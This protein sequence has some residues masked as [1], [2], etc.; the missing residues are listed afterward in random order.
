M[1]DRIIHFS[2]YHKLIVGICIVGLVTWGIYSLA[3]LPIDAV[4]DI[5]DNQVQVITRSPDLSAQEVERFITYP[6]ELE[7][8]NIPNVQQIRSISRFGLSVITVVFQEHVDI[9]WARQQISQNIQRAGS[10]IPE[11]LGRPEMGPISTGLGEVYQYV[12]YAQEGYQDQF[13]DTDLRS[14]QDWIIRR[15]LIGIPGVVEVNSSGGHLKQYEVAIDHS[16]LESFHLTMQDVLRAVEQNNEN[17]GGSYIEKQDYRYFIRGEGLLTDMDDIGN[18]VVVSRP[19]GYVLL[20]DVAEITIGHAPRFG[21][22]TLDG[23]GEVVAGQ[24]MMLKGANSMEVTRRVKEKMEVIK[25]GLPEGIV[26][27]PYLDRSKLVNSTTHTVAKNLIEGALIVI[28]ILVLLLGNLRAGLIVA[29]V[30]PL[31]MLFA[32][33]MMRLFGVSAN[34]MSLGAI[35]FG[36]I[37]DGAVIIVESILHHLGL[38]NRK[39]NATP[40]EQEAAVYTAASKIRRSA[41]FGEIIIL[42]V[43]LPILFLQGVEGKM[44]QPMAQT[45]SFAILGA[46]LLSLTYVP[47][48]SALFLKNSVENEQSL[49]QRI[50][51]RIYRIY[52]PMLDWALRHAAWILVPTI[53]LFIFSMYTLTRMGG[54]FIPTLEEGDFALHQILPSGSSLQKGVEV[55]AHLQEILTSKFPE[56]EKVVT[57]IG[58]AEIPTDIMPI[59]AGDIFVILKPK[60]EWVT[61]RSR[62][63]MFMAME[64]ELERFPGVIYE[65]TQPI[66]MRFNELMTGIRQDIAIKIYGED[67][68]VLVHLAHQAEGLLQAL[69]GIGDIQVEPT[70]GLQQMVIKYDRQKIAAYGVS[71]QALSDLIKTAF[72]GKKAGVLYEGDRK[73]DII[74]RLNKD[75]RQ[76][77]DNI[78]ELRVVLPSGGYAPLSEMATVSFEE[79]P[80]QISRDDTK[81][82]ITI[83]VNARN[84]DVATLIENIQTSFEQEL[85]LPPGYYVAYGGN[86]ENLERARARLGVVVPLA[87]GLIFILLYLTFHSVRHALL[88]FTAIPLSAIGGIWALYWRAMPFSISAGV[89]FIALFGVAV[90]NGI[91]L[92][93]YF[94]QLKEEGMT[95]LREIITEGTRIRLRPVL[96]TA[97][98]ASMGFLPM[99]LSAS[100]GAEVQRPLATVVIGGLITATFLTLF[101]IP[102]LYDIMERRLHRRTGQIAAVTSVL[103]VAGAWSTWAQPVPVLTLQE[104]IDLAID[105]NPQMKS[106]DTRSMAWQELAKT[107]V[108][109]LPL[110]LQVTGEEFDGNNQGIHSLG[111]FKS[112]RI[113]DLKGAYRNFYHGQSA[114]ERNR[115]QIQM[116]QLARQVG[117]D[118]L[119]LAAAR[120]QAEIYREKTES[121]QALY[122][123]N[124]RRLELGESGRLPMQQAEIKRQESQ[125]QLDQLE[126]EIQARADALEQWYPGAIFEVQPLEEIDTPEDTLISEHPW[127]TSF[128]LQQQSFA[129]QAAIT[130]QNNRPALNGGLRLQSVVGEFPFFGYQIGLSIPMAGSYVRQQRDAAKI[131]QDALAQER[132]FAQTQLDRNQVLL[133]SEMLQAQASAADLRD[134]LLPRAA[135]LVADY[136]VGFKAGEADYLEVVLASDAYFDLRE[137]LVGQMKK[138]LSRKLFLQYLIAE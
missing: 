43:Y 4:P 67:L 88:I 74:V 130:S 1:I 18:I 113:G 48:M 54:E 57:K 46:L 92:V 138:Y 59:E 104:A 70:A 124:K 127:L 76:G 135:Q 85:D 75:D 80:S 79:G 136:Q 36:L 73:Y 105:Q 109:D 69:P 131:R 47:M 40:A 99:A 72:A 39:A 44:F 13:D 133:Q 95:D 106:F 112:F 24:V 87:L 111:A 21:A 94:N 93:G 3:H 15:Q 101:V 28:F 7:L 17:T 55:S 78:S 118:Y 98:V 96:L 19:S 16:L 129:Q 110:N 81:R 61:A 65:F 38:R 84:L 83:G 63:E 9:Y 119:A 33:S 107:P 60:S 22:V 117:S 58:T 32:I 51:R 2:I 41:A 8:G 52:R 102:L 108:A 25:E 6:L 120:S 89:G 27:E 128:A 29:S 134:N 86:F 82:R 126:A 49:S 68:G 14:I 64:K 30:I 35:D 116:R 137:K 66:Q 45:V 42:I 97:S 91:V 103:L 56:V 122:E 31:S 132:A 11:E 5:T 23:K 90:L 53:A 114:I 115:K 37:V 100:A 34:L 50:I 121:Y 71:I 62:E 12:I 123:L 26:V 77:I 10:E 20:K 125:L